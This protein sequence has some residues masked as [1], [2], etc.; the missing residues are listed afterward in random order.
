MKSYAR[1][2]K[3]E[4]KEATGT[5]PR[6]AKSHGHSDDVLLR[7]VTLEEP[8]RCYILEFFRVRGVLYVTVEH[9]NPRIDLR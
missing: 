7:D 5:L 9:N 2:T 1:V 4:N 8:I 3:H 6:A